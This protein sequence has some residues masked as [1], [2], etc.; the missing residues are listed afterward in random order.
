MTDEFTANE[1]TDQDN[2]GDPLEETDDPTKQKLSHKERKHKE[3]ASEAF[4]AL[5]NPT[6]WIRGKDGKMQPLLLDPKDPAIA[7][8]ALD[9]SL[10]TNTSGWSVKSL[11]SDGTRKRHRVK[12]LPKYMVPSDDKDVGGGWNSS[13]HVKRTLKKPIDVI[14]PLLRSVEPVAEFISPPTSAGMDGRPSTLSRRQTVAKGLAQQHRTDRAKSDAQ[15]QSLPNATNIRR[16]STR[17]KKSI[18]TQPVGSFIGIQIVTTNAAGAKGVSP[19]TANQSPGHLKVST[20]GQQFGLNSPRSLSDLSPTSLAQAISAE[21][22]ASPNP[23]TVDPDQTVAS[24]SRHHRPKSYHRSAS[25]RSR[26]QNALSSFSDTQLT[27][28][29]M[30]PHPHSMAPPFPLQPKPFILFGPFTKDLER[31]EGKLVFSIDSQ[32]QHQQ[33]HQQHR[34]WRIHSKYFSRDQYLFPLRIYEPDYL[35][36]TVRSA[37]KQIE[38]AGGSDP[39]LW[40]SRTTSM[41]HLPHDIDTPSISIGSP[42]DC[43]IVTPVESVVETLANIID[44]TGMG[45]GVSQSL[46]A[47]AG[48]TK[49]WAE[50]TDNQNQPISNSLVTSTAEMSE[51]DGLLRTDSVVPEIANE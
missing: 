37:H 48:S 42:P 15:N 41:D 16:K 43:D 30:R 50:S 24:R 7:P 12:N 5:K 23:S 28:M 26:A 8:S 38:L 51:L 4:M 49:L 14:A 1:V 22:L 10:N 9:E 44:I 17:K 18:N 11:E 34:A 39:S 45:M 21:A 3:A 2:T 32:Q 13:V 25:S 46:V 33:H 31:Y 27:Y 20:E 36:P 19:Q 47:D 35:S 6:L 29:Q 40:Q